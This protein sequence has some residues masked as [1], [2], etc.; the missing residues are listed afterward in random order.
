MDEASRREPLVRVPTGVPGLDRVLHGGMFRGGLYMIQGEPGAGK[1]ILSNQICF[2]HIGAGGRAV[3]VT[4]LAELHTR[5]LAHLQS[6]QFFDPAPIGEALY[7]VS[8]YSNL[9]QSGLDGLLDL[10]RGVIRERR[11]SLMVIDG[12]E[13]ARNIA[14]SRQAFERFL[15]QLHAFLDATGGTALVLSSASTEQPHTEQTMVDGVI[16][17]TDRTVGL[18]AVRDLEVRKLRGTGYMRGRH[19]F[20]IS[21]AGITVYPRVEAVLATS[22]MAASADRSRLE[23]G[24]L[25]L[26]AML[27]GGVL[28][29]STT[30]VLGPPGS[31][32][33][34]LG[35]HFLTAGAREGQNGLYFGFYETPDRLQEKASNVGLEL[36]STG[37]G[38]MVEIVW[39]PSYERLL[40]ELAEQLLAVVERGK[41]RRLFIDGLKGFETAAAYPER[42][43]VSFSQH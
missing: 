35:L 26:D 42:L 19:A 40:D 15:Q 13:T 37:G 10:L 1:T 14:E 36:G 25:G 22:E 9:E 31:G 8:A 39:Q 29:G 16:A 23:S 11:A 28:A 34:L 21:D 17:L 24:V 27:H 38:G 32:K 30:M 5:M 7:Y 12:I 33:T 41:V 18:R 3:Y 2:H 43:S 6:L 4:L 20:R